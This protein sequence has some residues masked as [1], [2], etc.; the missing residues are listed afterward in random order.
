MTLFLS[1]R[2]IDLW[3][4][5][6]NLVIFPSTRKKSIDEQLIACKYLSFVLFSFSTSENLDDLTDKKTVEFRK[7]DAENAPLKTWNH[8]ARHITD[9][10]IEN[11]LHESGQP[12]SNASTGHHAIKKARRTNDA[13]QKIRPSTGKSTSTNI[14]P[15][16]KN[17]RATRRSRM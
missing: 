11:I 3:R 17:K 7:D 16:S 9:D 1:R 15:Q 8:I 4:Q 13:T 6:T 5:L 12:T 2:E 14:N 10:L